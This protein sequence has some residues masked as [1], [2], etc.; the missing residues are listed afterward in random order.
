MSDL[1][2]DKDNSKDMSQMESLMH[3]KFESKPVEEDEAL[4]L[5]P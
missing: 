1:L 3:L 2:W 5:A 4:D